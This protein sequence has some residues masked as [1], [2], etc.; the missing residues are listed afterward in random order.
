MRKTKTKAPAADS[1]I[2]SAQSLLTARRLMEGHG[3]GLVRV[4]AVARILGVP[5]AQRAHLLA[6]IERSELWVQPPTSG[7]L[8]LAPL[9]G[10]ID[11]DRLRDAIERDMARGGLPFTAD[12]LKGVSSA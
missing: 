4:P 5:L 9:A 7:P 6:W 10:C 1:R 12:H 11:L 3:S 2:T 8:A